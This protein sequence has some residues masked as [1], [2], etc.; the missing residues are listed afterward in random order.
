MIKIIF[1]FSFLIISNVLCA[2]NLEKSA[3]ENEFRLTGDSISFPLT[4]VN[5]FPFISGEV[6]GVK[7]KFMFDT[8]HQGALAINNNIVPLSSQKAH[9]NGFV[10]SGQ[11]FK[12][13]TND[14]I[15]DVRLVNGLH[16][17]NLKQIPS[18]NYDFLQDNITPDC[19]G[20]IGY[21]F[22]KGYTF[23]LDYAK[24][25]LTFYKHTQ[26]RESSKDF[27]AGEKVLAILDFEIRNLP[28]IP[29]I[30]VKVDD[31]E[32][33]GL[34]DTGGS[35]GLLEFTDK[36]SEKLVKRKFLKEYGKDG[37]DE[38]LFVLNKVRI[39]NQ[40]TTDFIG[41]HKIEESSQFKKAIGVAED[42]LLILSYR[43]LSK[44]KTVWDYDH[45]KIYVLEY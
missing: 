6:N 29:M 14:T 27:L 32:M 38:D 7:G 44:Y 2:Q 12:K 23:K 19:I 42:N 3:I 40:F 28:N 4:I 37:Y 26:E 18:A 35:Y 43:F 5:A 39:S 11:Q 33:L 34:F 22:F 9:G 16:F 13:Y 30:K 25:K 41:I 20:Y 21:D 8:G 10:A 1:S 24:R 45:K 15:D 17:Q 36:D 31:V